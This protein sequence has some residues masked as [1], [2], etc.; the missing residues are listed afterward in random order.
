M[1]CFCILV[2]YQKVVSQQLGLCVFR[3]RLRLRTFCFME[4]P[5]NSI[6][7]EIDGEIAKVNKRINK[8]VVGRNSTMNEVMEYILQTKGKQL[9][10][11]MAIAAS[12]LTGKFPDI[13]EKCAA[14]ELCHTASLIH[15]DI[16]DDAKERRGHPSVQHKYG[17]AI[18]VYAG[19][20]II[21]SLIKNAKISRKEP[22]MYVLKE[23]D[24]L[25]DGELDQYCNRFN[26]DITIEDYLNIIY[27]KT[28]YLFELAC[29]IGADAAKMNEQQKEKLKTFAEYFG[30]SFQLRDD[31]LDFQLY[32]DNKL[33]NKTINYDFWNGYFTLPIIFALQDKSTKDFIK[34]IIEKNKSEINRED[35]I[36]LSKKLNSIGAYA[37]TIGRIEEYASKA[38]TA[39]NDFDDSDYKRYLIE[40]LN[41][42]VETVTQIKFV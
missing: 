3:A 42:N 17:K 39:L 12:R 27:E 28:C 18:A 4:N 23:L 2:V 15:D 35:F 31:I 11:R 38:I 20:Y 34:N 36:S 16:I 7:C 8:I 14:L 6:I 19:D 9:R 5:M 24:R 40:M 41:K 37:Y 13:T 25:C 33:L 22:Y 10:P 21:F 26:Y 29:K 32:D 30:Y 1:L